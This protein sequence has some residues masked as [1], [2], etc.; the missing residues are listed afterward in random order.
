M[1]SDHKRNKECLDFFWV[2]FVFLFQSFYIDYFIDVL[3]QAQARSGVTNTLN[4]FAVC[5]YI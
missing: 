3:A 2:T 4:P 1:R 5:V